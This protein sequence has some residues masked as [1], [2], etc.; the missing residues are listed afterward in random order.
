MFCDARQVAITLTPSRSDE[1]HG[2]GFSPSL[3]FR[4]RFLVAYSL[5]GRRGSFL[6]L[7]CATYQPCF[8][9]S[10]TTPQSRLFETDRLRIDVTLHAGAVPCWL[11]RLAAV[12]CDGCCPS[13][14]NLFG[15]HQAFGSCVDIRKVAA[16]WPRNVC[17]G[18]GVSFERPSGLEAHILRCPIRSPS[19]KSILRSA[20]R[21][22]LRS[23]KPFAPRWR[24]AIASVTLRNSIIT[25]K[26]FHR[27]CDSPPQ[28]RA[29]DDGGV[30]RVNAER[31]THAGAW[32]PSALA[33]GKYR[34]EIVPRVGS[35]SATVHDG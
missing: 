28:A 23:I 6:G 14:R 29:R 16:A 31:S 12:E 4:L 3:L 26:I 10:L 24:S 20:R 15:A 27:R 21:S 1:A 5:K 33:R 19:R 8:W 13:V 22:G 7:P 25:F 2:L 30:D 18:N 32:P 17:S 35:G 11:E 9:L 34:R